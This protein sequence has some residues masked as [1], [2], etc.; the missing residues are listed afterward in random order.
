MP[1]GEYLFGLN[2]SVPDMAPGT[3]I[4]VYW[5]YVWIERREG[6][7]E[8]EKKRERECYFFFF[9]FS[10]SPFTFPNVINSNLPKIFVKETTLSLLQTWFSMHKGVTTRLEIMWRNKNSNDELNCSS[11]HVELIRMTEIGQ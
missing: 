1:T 11:R 5:N 3:S 9:S 4:H 7:K 6:G 8:R 2:Y 10:P